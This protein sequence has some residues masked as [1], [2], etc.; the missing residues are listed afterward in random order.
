VLSD[1]P[2]IVVCTVNLWRDTCWPAREEALRVFL[3]ATQPDI[4]AIQ[5]LHPVTRRVLDEELRG[6][7]RIEDSFPGWEYESN[8]YWNKSFFSMFAYGAQ[9]IGIT[10][11][12]C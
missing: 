3:R 1:N 2:R 10:E 4:L 12:Q 5:E 9:D 11:L 7:Q 8:V 6:H